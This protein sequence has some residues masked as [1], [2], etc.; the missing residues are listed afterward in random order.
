V[1]FVMACVLLLV[2]GVHCHV[3]QHLQQW[4]RSRQQPVQQTK[5]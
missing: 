1:E 4:L 3:L 5:Q 2:I